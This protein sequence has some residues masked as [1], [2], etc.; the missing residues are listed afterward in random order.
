MPG[1]AYPGSAG[2]C[3]VS[4]R[5]GGRYSLPGRSSSS[6]S[7][8]PDAA[9]ALAQMGAFLLQNQGSDGGSRL[10]EAEACLRLVG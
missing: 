4:S 10:L 5:V 1:K 8:S 2:A 9:S 3:T 6:E 7:L